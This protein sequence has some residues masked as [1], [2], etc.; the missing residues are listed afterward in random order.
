MIGQDD[1][2]SAVVYATINFLESFSLGGVAYVVMDSGMVSDDSP[3]LPL[4]LL[5]SVAPVIFAVLSY[6]ISYARFST[7]AEHYRGT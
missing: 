5:I 7:K 3:D 4:L 6:I 2:A 1:E